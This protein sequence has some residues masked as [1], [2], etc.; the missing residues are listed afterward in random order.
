MQPCL[1]RGCPNIVKQGR[2]AQHSTR[3]PNHGPD[4][5]TDEERKFYGSQHW[6]VTSQQHLRMEPLCRECQK[7]GRVSMATMTDHIV[8]I[9]FGG[10]RFDEKNLQSLCDPCHAKK[11]KIESQVR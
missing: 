4:T 8:P 11:R 5:K 10:S 1:E 3:G 7:R 9:R 6:R 2:C